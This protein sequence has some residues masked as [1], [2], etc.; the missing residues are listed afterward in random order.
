MGIAAVINPAVLVVTFAQPKTK[1]GK[2]KLKH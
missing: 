1:K 2:I